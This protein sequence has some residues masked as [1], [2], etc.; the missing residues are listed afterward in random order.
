MIPQE[1]CLST[2]IAMHTAV[3]FKTPPGDG[4]L[5]IIFHIPGNLYLRKRLQAR[6]VGR[7]EPFSRRG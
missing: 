4:T 6:K 5:K 1:R 3:F 7:S 2:A